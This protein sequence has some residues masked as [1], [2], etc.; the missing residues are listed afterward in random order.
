MVLRWWCIVGAEKAL[1]IYCCTALTP[2]RTTPVTGHGP[3]Q[4][5]HANLERASWSA[6]NES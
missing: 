5:E 3:L 6:Q 1:N 4:R 2:A